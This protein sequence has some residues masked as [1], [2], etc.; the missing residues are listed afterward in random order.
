VAAAVAFA[1]LSGLYL[2]P[3]QASSR[4]LVRHTRRVHQLPL[5][6]CYAVEIRRTASQE[7]RPLL[8]KTPPL[9]RVWT[10][11]DQFWVEMKRSDSGSSLVWGREKDGALW[12]VLGPNR[13]VRVS[14][15]QAPRVLTLLADV[16]S[17]NVDTLLDNVL[18]DCSMTEETVPTRSSWTRVVRAEPCS[19]RTRRWLS[20]AT[21]EIDT[22]AKVLRRLVIARNRLGVPFAEVVFSL[23]ETRP[24][25]D[26]KCQLES[27]L[28]RPFRI[29][30]GPVETAVKLEFLARW[31]AVRSGAF[32]STGR[33]GSKARE[34]R[35]RAVAL[36]DV[37]GRSHTPL[38]QR[39]SK[40]TVLFFLL[41]DCPISN[42]YAPEI[43]RICTTYAAK[44][45]AAFIVHAD[46]DV[47][48]ADAKKHAKDYSLSCPVL[49]DPAHVLV[50][51]T[52][53]TVAPEVAVIAPDGKVVYRGRI[54]DWYVDYGKRRAEPTQ[55]D[56]RNAL[57]AILKGKPVPRAT[58][59]ALGCPLP[60]P[61][62]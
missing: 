6:R 22:E 9:V 59:K 62:K 39:D 52:G 21:L 40:A 13:G 2:G 10:S 30:E 56:L 35:A 28:D 8:G 58:T 36:K 53:V 24:A 11:G 15:E 51:R 43:R 16:Y 47:S 41:P 12:A 5:E 14:A 1:F 48:A 60:E 42:A 17:L 49:L 18:H 33:P 55:R 57:D 23:V 45:V 61:K 7:G 31:F 4:E 38:S 3:V 54:D 50:E 27:H 32:S 44:K 20:H 25:R 26:A 46:P 34:D 29:H 37:N 19:Q